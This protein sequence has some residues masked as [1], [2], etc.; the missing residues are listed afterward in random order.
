M[1]SER[2]GGGGKF[3]LC[4]SFGLIFVARRRR[5]LFP[6]FSFLPLSSHVSRHHLFDSPACLS[7]SPERTV[8]VVKSVPSVAPATPSARL[9]LWGPVAGCGAPCS[10][11]LPFTGTVAGVQGEF[12]GTSVGVGARR[13]PVLLFCG[14]SGFYSPLSFLC[15]HPFHPVSSSVR[16]VLCALCRLGSCLCIPL[17]HS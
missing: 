16:R 10:P 1:I 5:R 12:K 9:P 8:V 15:C 7:G 17:V 6:V 14:F 13:I 4:F 3:F 11:C 2:A